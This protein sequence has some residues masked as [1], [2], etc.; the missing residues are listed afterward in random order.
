MP[1]RYD[2]QLK[3][4]LDVSRAVRH[5]DGRIP[6]FG[7]QDSGRVLPAGFARRPTHDNL[8][9]LGAAILGL[10]RPLPGAPDEEVAWTLGTDAWRRLA[11]TPELL[12]APARA[13][14]TGRIY[15]LD[16]PRTHLVIGCGDLGQNGNGGHGHNDTFSFELSVDGVPLVVDSGTYAY[17]FDVPARNLFR[18]TA[19][20]NTVEVDEEEINPIDPQRVFE[21]PQVA[22]IAVEAWVTTGDEITFSG[23][24]DGYARLG[25]P[26]HRRTVRLDQ[27]TDSVTV[28]D[29]LEGS[30][31][32]RAVSRFHLAVGTSVELSGLKARVTRGAASATVTF[33]GTDEVEVV[34]GSVSESYGSREEA[35]VLV[36]TAERKLPLRLAMVLVPSEVKV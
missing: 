31:L 11:A 2:E 16:S 23:F 15:C 33:E 14:H 18:S 24:H 20:H 35:P 22:R 26:A 21:L 34:A 5:N 17:T 19:A 27:E 7:D 30:G 32:H 8:L 1:A 13:F 3:R 29:E 12:G 25:V 36:A 9:W 6:L 28:V 4:M 10:A